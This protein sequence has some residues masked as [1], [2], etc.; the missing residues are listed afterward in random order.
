MSQVQKY[1]TH[2]RSIKSLEKWLQHSLSVKLKNFT[3]T[4]TLPSPGKPFVLVYLHLRNMILSITSN[5]YC[6]VN[7]IKYLLSLHTYCTTNPPHIFLGY[8]L[9]IFRHKLCVASTNFIKTTAPR[10]EQ[11]SRRPSHS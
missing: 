9:F 8:S 6:F 10:A 1:F 7:N 5:I 2:S 4:I 11:N 3:I